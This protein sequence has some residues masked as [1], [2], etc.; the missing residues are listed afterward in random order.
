MRALVIGGAGFVGGHLIRCLQEEWGWEVC[1]T[2]LP[3]ETLQ[4][5]RVK[6]FDLDLSHQA[7]ISRLLEQTKP[8]AVFHLAAQSSV[9]LSWKQPELTVNVNVN[10]ALHLL[11]AVRALSWKPRVLLIGSGEEY[12]RVLPGELPLTEESPLRPGNL[13][14]ATKA[15]QNMIGRIYAEAYQM[16]L[17][18][19]RAFNHIGPGQSPQF[20]VSDFCKQVSEIEQGLR[21]PVLRVG[22]L[23]ARR[24]FTDVRDVVRA[25]ALL[26]QKGAPGETYNV[27][28]GRA[29]SIRSLLDQIIA[30]SGATIRVE[31]DPAKF[32][33]V[34]VPVIEAGTEKLRSCTG[35]QPQIPLAQTLR[36]TLDGW[37]RWAETAKKIGV[38]DK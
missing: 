9:A 14:A 10:G 17:L 11:D 16:D 15:M 33:P 26:M 21:E 25:Y 13:Y 34:D 12:G 23:E 30:L 24:D 36:E 28:S 20:V 32:R 22:N 8:E 4:D 19:V 6:A 37:R 38:S 35:W 31:A 1:A 2:K 7:A 3:G 18:M 5:S 27:G 29:V